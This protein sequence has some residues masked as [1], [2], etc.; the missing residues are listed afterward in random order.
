MKTKISA[1]IITKNEAKNIEDCL[2]SLS[3]A[4]EIVVVDDFSEDET[5]E[6]C[7][8]YNARFIKNRFTGFRDQKSFAMNNTVN[9]WVLE[10]DA[11]ERVSDAMK[12]AIKSL[13]E[14]DYKNFDGFEFRRKNYFRGKWL[15]FGGQYPDFKLRLYNKKRG[16]WSENNI[17]ER[18]IINGSSKKIDAD[19]IHYQDVD[20]KRLFLK[21]LRYN[22]LSA[23]ELFKSGRRASWHNYTIR[24]L[25][26]FLYRYFF[27]LGIL[28]G[29]EG[30]IIS[31]MGAIGTFA[32][33]MFLKEMERNGNRY[34]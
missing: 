34:S 16:R 1:I 21:T 26:T 24:P 3:F 14:I 13:T 33:Y 7:K 6:I 5:E 29:L 11:D 22:Q 17:H 2:K 10:I 19:I 15:R 25:Y 9:D 28:D 31:V 23:E 30:F 27:R 18:F 32:K 4:D 12:D 8:R 20:L